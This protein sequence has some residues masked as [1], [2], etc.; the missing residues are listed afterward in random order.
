MNPKCY[1]SAI[2]A[3]KLP[4]TAYDGIEKVF[5]QHLENKQA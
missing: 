5:L 4:E 3:L 2:L 1:K